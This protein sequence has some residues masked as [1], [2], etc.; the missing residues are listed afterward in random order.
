MK[1]LSAISFLLLLSFTW[2]RQKAGCDDG[3]IRGVNLGGWLL[4]EPW[5]TPVFFEAV[6]V[7][8]LQVEILYKMLVILLEHQRRNK[9]K[10]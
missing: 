6:N 10:E 9:Y 5:I 7:G 4:L 8:E 1:S 3:I 2:A